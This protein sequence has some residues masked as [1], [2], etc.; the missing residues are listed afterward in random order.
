MGLVIIGV[1]VAALV[2][3]LVLLFRGRG[4]SASG[5]MARTRIGDDGF[6]IVG[7]FTP[8]TSVE[9]QA[10]VA[11]TWRRGTA[12]VSGAE[13]FVYTGTPPTDVRIL[14]ESGVT[15]LQ[16]PSAGP[17]SSDDGPFAGFPSAY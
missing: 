11:G 7:D 6:F 14:G 16:P 17:A 12:L 4:G 9:Y 2:A 8:G 15:S 10:L 5:S 1:V 3:A 13:T